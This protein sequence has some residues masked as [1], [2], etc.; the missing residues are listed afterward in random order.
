MQGLAWSLSLVLMAGVALIFLRVV[1]GASQP[2][3]DAGTIAAAGYRWRDRLF[4]VVIVAGVAISFATLR[5]WPIPGHA[6]AAAT[7]DVIV[8]AVGHQWRWELDR[9]TVRPG[10]LVEFEVTSADVN[11]GFAIYRPEKSRILAQAQ[12]MPGYTNKLQVRFDEPGDYE[13]L[14]LEYCGLAHHAMRAV[15]KVRADS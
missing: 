3:G 7:P 5:K 11:H 4:W 10:E 6:A 14:C 13:V 15:I 1:A 12:A 9:D 8:R 2:G